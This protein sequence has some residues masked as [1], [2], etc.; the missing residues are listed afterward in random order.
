MRCADEVDERVVRPQRGGDRRG[1]ERVSGDGCGTRRDP[2]QGLRTREHTNLVSARQERRRKA[3]AAM[4]T[5]VGALALARAVD[6]PALSDEI[7]EAARREL[8]AATQ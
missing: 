7:L 1:V 4:S 2:G 5:L 8:A 3:L 6:D